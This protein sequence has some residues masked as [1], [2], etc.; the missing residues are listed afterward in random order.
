MR[1]EKVRIL[2]IFLDAIV[3]VILGVVW[4]LALVAF[5]FFFTMSSHSTPFPAPRSSDPLPP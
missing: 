4:W 1:A 3:V 2:V 5:L